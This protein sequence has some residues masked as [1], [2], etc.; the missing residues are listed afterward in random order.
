[1][2][3]MFAQ[4]PEHSEK[5]EVHIRTLNNNG[6]INDYSLHQEVSMPVRIPYP[7]S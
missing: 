7:E 5:C 1:M 4:M 6:V 2:T 3:K